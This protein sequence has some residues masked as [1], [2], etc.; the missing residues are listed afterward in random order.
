MTLLVSVIGWTFTILQL[1]ILLRVIA[2]W[3]GLSLYSKW[4]RWVFVLSEPILRPLR[5]VIPTLGMIDITPLVAYF[6]LNIISS[7]LIG[8][9]S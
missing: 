7:V 6:L 4:L 9:L 2:S 3:V 1:A 5:Q 8:M